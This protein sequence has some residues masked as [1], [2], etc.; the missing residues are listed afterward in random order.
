MYKLLPVVGLLLAATP[1]PAQT[2][3]LAGAFGGFGANFP[4]IDFNSCK[5]E[6]GGGGAHIGALAGV[7]RG[8]FALFVDGGIIAAGDSCGRV[9]LANGPAAPDTSFQNSIDY[10]LGSLGANLRVDVMRISNTTMH[11][12]M[13]G[14]AFIPTRDLIMRSSAKYLQLGT[15]LRF[16]AGAQKFGIELLYHQFQYRREQVIREAWTTTTYTPI[17]T[18]TAHPLLLRA[19]VE[20]GR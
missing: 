15:G 7:Q 4:S 19:S 16:G 2:R 17:A 18:Q 13:G 8:R 12:R 1:L 10:P 6:S 5:G 11:F 9:E 3:F 14:G 20:F